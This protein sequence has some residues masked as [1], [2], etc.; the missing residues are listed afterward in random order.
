MHL[1]NILP[2]SDEALPALG[3]LQPYG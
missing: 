3:L 2:E 1:G